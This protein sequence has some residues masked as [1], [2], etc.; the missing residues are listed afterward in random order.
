[1]AGGGT[2]PVQPFYSVAQ[3][4]IDK[5][6]NKMNSADF[7]KYLKGKGVK[8]DEIQY[9]GIND[10]IQGKDSITKQEAME[11]LSNPQLE[12]KTTP[13]DDEIEAESIRQH[14]VNLS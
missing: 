1:M 12:V 9:A 4:A 10:A 5:M 3:E 7:I 8:D 11:A 6:P 13:M 14:G 2:P